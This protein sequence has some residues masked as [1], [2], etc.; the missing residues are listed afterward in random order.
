MAVT[1]TEYS[2][3]NESWETW[4]RDGCAQAEALKSPVN[5]LERFD[6]YTTLTCQFPF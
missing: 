2:Q 3:I 1:F 5:E 4:P 6:Y